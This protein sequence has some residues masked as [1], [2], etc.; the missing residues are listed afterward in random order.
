M[1]DIDDFDFPE[2]APPAIIVCDLCQ[3]AFF[4]TDG[5]QVKYEGAQEF[6]GVSWLVCSEDCA[7]ALCYASTMMKAVRV[8]TDAETDADT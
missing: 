2:P 6:S 8:K 5:F 4:V 7:A 3:E 1:D